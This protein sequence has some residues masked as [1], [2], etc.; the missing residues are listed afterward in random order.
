MKPL[1]RYSHGVVRVGS[2]SHQSFMEPDEDG[3]WYAKD[4]VDALI[5]ELKI[6]AHR[7]LLDQFAMHATEED[8][9]A[10]IPRTVGETADLMASLG[11][12]RPRRPGD[13][14]LRSYTSEQARALRHWARYQH[15]KA[16]MKAREK[17]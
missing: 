10:Y 15:A 16:M 17:L 8:V 1:T 5:D 4:E 13:D 6:E 7:T 9:Q 11:W 3:D 2:A 12:I 14:V